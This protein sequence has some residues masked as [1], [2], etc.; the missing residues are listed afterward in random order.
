M[1][2]FLYGSSNVYRHY[3]SAPPGLGHNL[4]LIE[5]TRK[6]VFDAHVLTL[7]TLPPGSLLVTAVLPNF[8][9]DACKGLEVG[10][11]SL[12]GK[13]QITAHLESLG[14]L[15]R[16]SPDSVAVVIPPIRRDFP[17]DVL[18]KREKEAHVRY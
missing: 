4:V 17:G 7:G 14:G 10:E 9:V 8:I 15:L 18:R 5:C 11:A 13:Q 3:A 1:S 6:A 16:D 12:F 2:R